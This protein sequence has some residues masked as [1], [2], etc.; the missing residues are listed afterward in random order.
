MSAALDGALI[1][2]D[3]SSTADQHALCSTAV[4]DGGVGDE[5][6]ELPHPA[7]TSAINTAPMTPIA[8]FMSFLSRSPRTRFRC[9]GDRGIV[10]NQPDGDA[11]RARHTR[12]RTR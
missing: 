4:V 6:D 7:S 1:S 5:R 8:L 11:A 3:N 2:F 10:R 9:S 12:G